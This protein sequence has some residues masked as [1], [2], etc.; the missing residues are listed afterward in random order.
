MRQALITIAFVLS[1]C[2][3][4]G[5]RQLSSTEIAA[6]QS[7]ETFISRHGYTAAGHPQNLPVENVEVLDP[8]ASREELVKWR[9]ATLEPKA[10]GIA[11]AAPGVSW[12]LFHRLG[13][14]N[15]F[16]AVRVE[17]TSAVQVVHSQLILSQLHWAPVP[18]H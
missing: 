8:L 7:A 16:R 5:S 2:A 6:V 11:P 14:N 12:V 9:S 17:D 13:D 18:A 10:F 1:A 15:E 4:L 3:S